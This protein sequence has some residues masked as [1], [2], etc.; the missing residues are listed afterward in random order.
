MI[1]GDLYFCIKTYAVPTPYLRH[2]LVPQ[3][4]ASYL[5]LQNLTATQTA[6]TLIGPLGV[7]ALSE[8]GRQPRSSQRRPMQNPVD[9]IML[10]EYPSSNIHTFND[11][12]TRRQRETHVYALVFSCPFVQRG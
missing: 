7:L 5:P 1:S 2:S 12:C 6:T 10:F 4:V 3:T 9:L 11:L 8:T